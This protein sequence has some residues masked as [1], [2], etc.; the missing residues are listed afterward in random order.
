M[1]DQ[2]P[3]KFLA[4][5]EA[6][7]SVNVG[8]KTS[9]LYA[10]VAASLQAQPGV[11]AIVDTITDTTNSGRARAASWRT[12]LRRQGCAVAIRTSPDGVRTVYAQAVPE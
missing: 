6:P 11:W 4:P 2:P 10:A 8:A 9:P 7:P 1:T 3:L 12:S 5:G